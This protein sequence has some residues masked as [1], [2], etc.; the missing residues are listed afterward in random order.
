M[1]RSIEVLNHIELEV[2]E[3]I[4]GPYTFNLLIKG[5]PTPPTEAELLQVEELALN[6]KNVRS[7][8]HSITI[9]IEGR[10]IKTVCFSAAIIG[11]Q[12][13]IYPL[14]QR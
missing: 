4:K 6:A 5:Y 10:S 1:R 2:R 8:L 7:H 13:D 11:E 9:E 12:T 3:Y 14:H